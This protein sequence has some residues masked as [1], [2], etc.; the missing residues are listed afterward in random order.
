MGKSIVSQPSKSYQGNEIALS[1]CTSSIVEE[2]STHNPEIKGLNPAI[3]AGSKKL[4][5]KSL[6]HYLPCLL[7]VHD[8][9]TIN[10]IC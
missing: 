2:H 8:T 3:G 10:P 4:E 1:M 6:F 7:E 9:Y 5:S